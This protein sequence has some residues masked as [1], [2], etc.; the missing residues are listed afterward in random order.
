MYP[1]EYYIF[2]MICQ[3]FL[4]FSP[5]KLDPPVM[6]VTQVNGSLSVILRAPNTPYRN[7]KGR[8]VPMETYYE[9]VY[10]VFIISNS[11]EKVSSDE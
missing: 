7:Q 9:L 2:K 6:D 11:L 5:A 4:F 10:R 8:N 1:C 3:H